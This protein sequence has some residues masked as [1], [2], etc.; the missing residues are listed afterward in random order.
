MNAPDDD[1]EE[2]DLADR[3]DDVSNRPED[4][5]LP[6]EPPEIPDGFV[7]VTACPD[8]TDVK[9]MLRT[10]ALFKWDCGWAHGVVKRKVSRRR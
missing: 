10:Q 3:F 7:L 8:V 2:P 6:D 5:D 1:V 9:K 4:L